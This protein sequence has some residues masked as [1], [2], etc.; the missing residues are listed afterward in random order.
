MGIQLLHA[1]NHLVAAAKPAG[2]PTVPDE[3]GD[4]SLLD[5]VR[6]WIRV[7]AGKPGNV[8]VGV[9][10]R[11][12]RPVSGAVLFARTSK[13]ASR[14]SDA[15]RT[16]SV[17]KSYLGVVAGRIPTSQGEVELWL[18]KDERRN[19][20]CRVPAS[21]PGA[22]RALARYAVLDERRGMTLVEL[23]PLTGRSH[24][25]RVLCQSLGAPLLG[26]LKYGAD[27]PLPDASIALHARRL[28]FPHPVGKHEVVISCE[29]PDRE[30][31]RGWRSLPA[32]R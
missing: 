31:W 1:D 17:E 18:V 6:E 23:T 9:V 30:W 2:L 20:V 25:L 16:R 10:H 13:A 5:E 8:F 29:P 28:A 21:Q 7:T 19:V 24:Q 14:L 3:T 4:R 27:R 22:K 15:W 12:D 32:E 11:L 26:D